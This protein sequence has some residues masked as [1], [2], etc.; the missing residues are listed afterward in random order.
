VSGFRTRI[1]E[2]VDAGLVAD[3][4]T[5]RQLVS[6]RWAIVWCLTPAGLDVHRGS[7]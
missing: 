6:H 1:S 3:S 4:G 7:S 5:K 2:L